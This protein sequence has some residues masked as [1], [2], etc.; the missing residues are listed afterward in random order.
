MRVYLPHARSDSEADGH[1]PI[2]PSP[3]EKI[4]CDNRVSS[5]VRF[6]SGEQPLTCT[7]LIVLRLACPG[8]G[9][10]AAP[11]VYSLKFSQENLVVQFFLC[12]TRIIVSSRSSICVT[13]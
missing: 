5:S 9:C 10:Y 11:S 3:S 2:P 4:D 13:I 6:D 1:W 8:H 7:G 12:I